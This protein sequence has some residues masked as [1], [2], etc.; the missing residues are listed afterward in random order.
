MCREYTNA[1][2]CCKLIWCNTAKS[3]GVTNETQSKSLTLSGKGYTLVELFFVHYFNK[4][5]M[6]TDKV[7][8]KSTYGKHIPLKCIIPFYHVYCIFNVSFEAVVYSVQLQ[9]TKAMM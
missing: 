1:P 9:L 2:A 5:C 3:T 6:K 8:R 4:Q 7:Q